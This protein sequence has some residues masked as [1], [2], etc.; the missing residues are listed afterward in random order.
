MK[1]KKELLPEAAGVPQLKIFR[2][3]EEGGADDRT[4][5]DPGGPDR[6]EWERTEAFWAGRNRAERISARLV[7]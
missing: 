3:E 6:R 7:A 2:G 5:P 4:P 1:C